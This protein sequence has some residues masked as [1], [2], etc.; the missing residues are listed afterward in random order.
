MGQ[1]VQQLVGVSGC[2]VLSVDALQRASGGQ[3]FEDLSLLLGKVREACEHH[4][5]TAGRVGVDTVVEQTNEIAQHL[6]SL[7]EQLM[8][9]R[10][11]VATN[12]ACAGDF[13]LVAEG[14]NRDPIVKTVVVASDFDDGSLLSLQC[15]SL[16][17]MPPIYRI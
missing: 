17:L 9:Y 11:L 13:L 15:P 1:L 2:D 4:G 5:L 10:P 7:I 3:E 14:R 12:E 16:V 8:E 6:E